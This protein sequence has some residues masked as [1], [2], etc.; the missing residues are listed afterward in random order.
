MVH[1]WNFDLDGWH[2]SSQM[3]AAIIYTNASGGGIGHTGAGYGDL[4]TVPLY[5]WKDFG[6]IAVLGGLNIVAPIGSNSKAQVI[7]TSLN[8]WTFTPEFAFTYHPND[9]FMASVDMMLLFNTVNPAT[10]YHSGSAIN[11]DF[12][13]GYRPFDTFKSVELGLSG[14]YFAQFTDDIR[15]GIPVAGGGNRGRVLG[16]GPQV[17]FDF[18]GPAGIIFKWQ[19]EFFVLNRPEG[20][21]F[22]CQFALKF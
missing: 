9:R 18:T 16:I 17:R 22:W 5:V 2:L 11:F 19:K 7:N 13:A 3:V 12:Q 21:R 20:D 10:N 14:Y 1:T 8:Y 4:N 15:N 6:E